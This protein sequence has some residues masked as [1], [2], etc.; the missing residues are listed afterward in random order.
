RFTRSFA[1]YGDRGDVQTT[2]LGDNDRLGLGDFRRDFLD[3]H[4]F[5]LTIETHG[6][7]TPSKDAWGV[8]LARQPNAAPG[9]SSSNK[10]KSSVGRRL[11]W[12]RTGKASGLSGTAEVRLR[13]FRRGGPLCY[14]A[15]AVFD[16]SIRKSPDAA[17]STFFAVPPY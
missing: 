4:R 8:S 13:C 5:L 11:R 12:I 16:S 2:V 14:P 6:L 7:N 17:Q 1:Q 9:L 10:K 3:H 15:P